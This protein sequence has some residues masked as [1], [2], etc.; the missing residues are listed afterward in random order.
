VKTQSQPQPRVPFV[1]LGAQLDSLGSQL[2]GAIASVFRTGDF[3]LGEAVERFENS[4]ASYCGARFAIGVDSGLSALEL[5]LIAHGIGPGDEVITP[6]NTFIATALAISHVGATPVLVD[7]SP[8]TATLDADAVAAAITPATAALLPVHL[9]GQPA[10]MDALMA[11][12]ERHGLVV[13]EDACQAHGATYKTRRVGSIGHSAAF[14][15]YP[16]KNL[17]ACGDGGMV[18]TNDPAVADAVRMLRNYGQ[19]RKYHHTRIGYNKR[20]DTLQAAIL[21]VKLQHL[22]S[23]NAQ[24]NQ[25]AELYNALLAETNV[26]TP[27]VAPDRDS[28]WHL[29][30][31]E[32]VQRDRVAEILGQQGIATGIHYPIP[33]HLQPAY[34]HLGCARGSFPVTER[35]AEQILS[36]PMYA[37]LTSA[38]Q[39]R[40]ASAIAQA[41]E[42]RIAA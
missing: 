9:Y 40:V 42:A 18:V 28:V 11:F 24:R 26:I 13:I 23:W 31:I 36:L 33:I 8:E 12:A 10:D 21:D 14:S 22:D 19:D 32:C 20:L 29:Y 5:A 27:R 17:G 41:T 7:V 30:V 35:K 4:F 2:D 15:F 16:G 39:E 6:A 1:D 38:M 37:E 25:H 3:I 34:Q